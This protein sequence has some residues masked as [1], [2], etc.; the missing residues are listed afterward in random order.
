[1]K[2]VYW[3]LALLVSGLIVW[4]LFF[5]PVP[6][7]KTI[8][9][10]YT[11]FKSGEQFTNASNLVKWYAP[12]T[13]NDTA[14][15]SKETGK[16]IITSGSYSAVISDISLFSAVI[17]AK[18][19]GK[20]KAFSFTAL[21]DSSEA[22]A[23][24]VTLAYH[25]TLFRKWFVKTVLEKNANKS[26]ENLRD[27]MTD[28]RRFYGFEIQLVPVEDTLFLF[29]RRAVPVTQRKEATKKIFEQLI[30]YAEKNGAG[31]NGNRIYY[32]LKSGDEITIFA[33]IGVSN[34][35]E[36]APDDVL[37]YKRMP[38]GKKLLM[39]SYQGPFNQSDKAF[40]ALEAFKADHT[41]SSM[42]IPFQK[43][44]S[45]GFDFE[46]DQVVQLKI[47]YPVF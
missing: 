29:S 15:I 19:H 44:M 33:S 27:Y 45:D 7:K 1:M 12:F 16:H 8:Q 30:A 43:F 20:E 25:T 23:T 40:K 41:L 3:F 18:H 38:Y 39:T 26:L 32:T 5:Y 36:T 6:V 22:A 2:R 42:A 28:T 47:Y 37:Q 31:Y 21:T 4:G 10:P 11:M 17:K 24:F 14:G 46:D 35:T 34:M 13:I 9:V